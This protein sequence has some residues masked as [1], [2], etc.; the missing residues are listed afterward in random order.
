MKLLLASSE[1]HP[2]SKT[3][4]LG[5]MVGALAKALAREGHQVGLVTPLY[6]GIREKFPGIKPFDWVLNLQLGGRKISGKVC[7]LEPVPNLTI[8][9]IEQP[10]FYLRPGLYSNGGFD[11]HD[12]AERFTF[13]SKAV[14]HLARYLPWQPEFV[15]VHDWHVG[16]VPLLI[17]H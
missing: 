9:F 7:T 2:Y 4:G 11:Y 5:D 12:N 15:H 10:E 14:V 1:V 8:Y 6:S 17:H 13:L 16:L 3:G